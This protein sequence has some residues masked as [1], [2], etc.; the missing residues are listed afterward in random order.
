[1]SNETVTQT[2]NDPHYNK[3]SLQG[4][5]RTEPN[6]QSIRLDSVMQYT[7]A[8]GCDLPILLED[9]SQG[10]SAR[11]A[12][13]SHRLHLTMLNIDY[14]AEPCMT[15]GWTDTRACGYKY[16]QYI[17]LLR[18]NEVIISASRVFGGSRTVE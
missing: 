5:H 17:S 14:T 15:P 3:L 12:L 2:V 8:P 6:C 1:V 18:A 13:H 10:F 11:V 4:K 16:H 7:Q 9:S